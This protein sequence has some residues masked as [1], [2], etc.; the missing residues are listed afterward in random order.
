M[1]EKKSPLKYE[2]LLLLLSVI[3]GFAFPAQEIGMKNG[4]G[5]MYFTGLRF[6]LGCLVLLPVIVWRSRRITANPDTSRF[7]IKGSIAAGIFLFLAASTQ[8]I[9]LQ[10]TTSANAGFITGFYILFVPLIGLLLGHKAARSLWTGIA[11]CIMGFYLLSVTSDFKVSK[12]D[13]LILACAVL[14]ASQI[15]V[16]DRVTIS[17]DPIKIACLQFAVT[18]VLGLTA[19]AIFETCTLENIKAGAGALAYA[20]I[21]SVGVA[22]TLQVICQKRCPPGPAAVIMSMEAVFAAI[23]GY[24]ILDQKLT[25]RAI[26]GCF[27]ILC[28]MLIVQLVPMIKPRINNKANQ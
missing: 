5:P 13:L 7:P 2:L 3:W 12:G 11:V 23:A 17:G 21:M 14:W 20:G 28:G 18:A 9:G 27:L 1:S 25:G 22:F 10:Y 19:A 24:L 26:L 4:I 15:L 16:I 6:A 8:Q